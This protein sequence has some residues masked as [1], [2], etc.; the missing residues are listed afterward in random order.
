MIHQ[1]TKIENE[2]DSTFTCQKGIGT[3]ATPVKSVPSNQVLFL[4][5]GL[6]W[7]LSLI[8]RINYLKSFY[9]F[10]NLSL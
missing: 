2:I 7:F 8:F 6:K 5:I 9:S 1:P 10:F 4:K 3:S